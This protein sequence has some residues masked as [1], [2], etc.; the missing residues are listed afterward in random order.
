M[1]RTA[2]SILP[3]LVLAG[4]S[5]NQ[6]YAFPTLS[7][8]VVDGDEAFGPWLSLD[9]APGGDRLT[10]T[11]YD[12]EQGALGFAT[13]TPNEAG[14]VSWVHEQVDGYTGDDGLDRYDRGTYSSHAVASDGTVWVAYKDNKN[15]GLYASQRVGPHNWTEGALVDLGEGLTPNAGTWASLDLDASGQPVIAHYDEGAKVLRVSRLGSE[16]WTTETAWQ[17]ADATQVGDTGGTTIVDADTGEYS[18]LL[19]EDGVEYI[20]FY[21]RASGALHLLEG[22]SG[23]Y[24]HT[25]VDDEGDVGQWPSLWTDGTTLQIAY[26]DVGNQQ[27]RMATRTAGSWSTAVV[28]EGAYTGADSELFVRDDNLAVVY[29]DGFNNDQKLAT[30]N[31]GGW[32]LETTDGEGIAV[33]FHNEV[34]MANGRW[35]VASYDHTNKA[36]RIQA[37]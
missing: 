24:T 30:W 19:I 4:C 37:L 8:I 15:G 16:G 10:L 27:L 1:L 2:L 34:A 25:V 18:K 6:D 20:A 5:C 21:D 13:G 33:G 31:N 14:R 22:T 35:F 11:Y 36:M 29:F 23:A 26:H 3:A 17:G 32:D 28:D 9:T 7:D 12:I